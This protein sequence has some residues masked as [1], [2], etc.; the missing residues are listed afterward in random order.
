MKV[1]IRHGPAVDGV[2]HRQRHSADGVEFHEY[3]KLI[4]RVK[5]IALE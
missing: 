5:E 3:I 1:L 2:T 4:E